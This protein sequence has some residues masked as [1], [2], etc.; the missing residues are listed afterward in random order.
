MGSVL[1]VC[2]DTRKMETRN[3]RSS[4][5]TLG[6]FACLLRMLCVGCD[7]FV[8]ADSDCCGY[9]DVDVD[10]VDDYY[11]PDVDATATSV[12]AAAADDDNNNGGGNDGATNDDCSCACACQA[13]VITIK[14]PMEMAEPVVMVTVASYSMR[15]LTPISPPNTA[16]SH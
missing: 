10:D 1:R 5:L 15:H 2:V 16:Q 14:L 12:D 3:L 4:S 13:V 11:W 6:F 8:D 7:T 9:V